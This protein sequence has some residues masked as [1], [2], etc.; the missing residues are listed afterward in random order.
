MGFR[1]APEFPSAAHA[2]YNAGAAHVFDLT[3]ANGNNAPDPCA[4]V[5][6]YDADCI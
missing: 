2:A 4:E 6:S 3:V 5:L 1:G